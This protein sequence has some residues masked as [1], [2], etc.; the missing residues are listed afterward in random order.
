MFIDRYVLLILKNNIK[1]YH[2]LNILNKYNE[3]CN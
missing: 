3:N 2:F 1:V